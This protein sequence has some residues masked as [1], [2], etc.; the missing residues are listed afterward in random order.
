LHM[1]PWK[2]LLS[3]G[4]KRTTYVALQPFKD[5]MLTTDPDM[6]SYMQNQ[7]SEHPE[8]TLA[9]PTTG[10]LFAA[11]S[12]MRALA[13]LPAPDIPAVSFLGTNEHIVESDPI[14]DLMQRWPKGTLKI[15]QGCKHEVLME[16]LAV[17]TRVYDAIDVLAHKSR[18]NNAARYAGA[19]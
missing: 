8:L 7:A 1:T 3:P 19:L 16:T 10:W 4:S 15:E 13:A 5:N 2:T 9:G 11:L 6:Y 12:E 18:G 14:H 17:R